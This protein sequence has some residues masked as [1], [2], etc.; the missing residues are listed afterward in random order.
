[1]KPYSVL[2]S[3]YIKEKPEYL[4]AALDS[5]VDQ[6]AAPDE[7]VLIEDGPLTDELYEVIRDFTERFPDLF[8]IIVNAENLG[9]GP[10]LC[11]GVLAC[12]NELVARMDT[13]DIA[14]SDRCEKQLA[15]FEKHPQTSIVGGQIREF[16]NDPEN[17]LCMR[18]VPQSD[19]QIKEFM[20]RRNPFNHMTVMFKKADII[21]AGNYRDWFCNEDYDLWIRL[22]LNN[23]TMA[24]LP[25]VL[26]NAR[27]GDGM[28]ER[29]GGSKYFKS[30]IGIQKMMLDNQLISTPMFCRHYAER[31]IIA[32]MMPGSV[33]GWFYRKFARE[34]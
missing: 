24:N 16:E 28:Y 32:R 23:Y 8:N 17:V 20:K 22:A 18:I 33:R 11:K 15:F 31:F 9:L 19:I 25:D 30:E 3:V 10:S 2:M 29:R 27:V 4:R 21:D 14:V 12:G 1:M 26:V 13:D 5:M 7:I 6:T 34:Q